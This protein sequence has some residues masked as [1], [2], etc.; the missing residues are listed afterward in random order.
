[1]KS[2]TTTDREDDEVPTMAVAA[3]RAA[4]RRAESSGR[5]MVLVLDGKLVRVDPSG[6]TVLKTLPPRQK[7]S[8]REKRVSA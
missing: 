3:L 7:V 1:M 6:Q 2:E 8:I 5:P 4:Q